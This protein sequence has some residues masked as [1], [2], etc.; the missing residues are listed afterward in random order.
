MREELPEES[1]RLTFHTPPLSH[2]PSYGASA[3]PLPQ[4][5]LTRE[6]V[7]EDAVEERNVL[8]EELGQVDVV[9]RAEHQNVLGGVGEGALKGRKERRSKGRGEGARGRGKARG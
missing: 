2:L 6:K 4:A 9:D 3:P 5:R 1:A 8:V 7:R